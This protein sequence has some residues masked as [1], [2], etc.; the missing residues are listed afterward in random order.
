MESATDRK[1]ADAKAAVEKEQKARLSGPMRLWLVHTLDTDAPPFHFANVPHSFI[2]AART[3]AQA[4]DIAAAEDGTYPDVWRDEA[5]TCCVPLAPQ[6]PGIIASET[7]LR[8]TVME[9][10]TEERM[11][12]AAAKREADATAATQAYSESLRA[13]NVEGR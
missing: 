9:G 7:F 10:E 12:A 8:R 13:A 2:V 1:E 6:E 3:P 11:A 5:Q 4:R